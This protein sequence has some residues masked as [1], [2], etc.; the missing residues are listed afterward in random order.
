MIALRSSPSSSALTGRTPL[1]IALGVLTTNTIEQAL[2]R[3][4]GKHGNKGYD[5]ALVALEM[6]ICAAP[7]VSA[8]RE[9]RMTGSTRRQAGSWRCRC[10]IS[11]K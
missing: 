8:W 11:S 7:G 6:A 9:D 4:G 2:E 10:S 5:A 1:P 3:A